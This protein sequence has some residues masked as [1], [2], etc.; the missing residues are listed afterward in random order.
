MKH[1]L[2]RIGLAL[3]FSSALAIAAGLFVAN[4]VN[5]QRDVVAQLQRRLARKGVQVKSITITKRVPFEVELV[6]QSESD[7]QVV[8]PND[9]LFEIIV[10][11]EVA[12]VAKPFTGIDLIKM[13]VLNT[14]AT[15]IFWAD[16]PV[17]KLRRFTPT[18]KSM[19]ETTIGTFIRDQLPLHDLSPNELIVTDGDN[20]GKVLSIQLTAKDIQTANN[21]VPDLITSLRNLLRQMNEEQDAQ[22]AI[23]R[24]QL[25]EANGRPLLKYVKDF[26]L[27]SESWWQADD[28]TTDWFP[29]PPPPSNP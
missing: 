6:L 2:I 13:T 10:E 28:L 14:K 9:P 8:S 29:H 7:N 3:I 27:D 18:S 20:G 24:V 23:A 16:V 11:H 21:A 17:K 25:I 12:A 15:P 22:I 26:Q 4:E 19:N 1:K 5:A